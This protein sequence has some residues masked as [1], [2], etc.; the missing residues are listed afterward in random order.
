MRHKA[1]L[2]NDGTIALP[3]DIRRILGVEEGGTIVFEADEH[4]VHLFTEQKKSFESMRGIW[5]HLGPTTIEQIIEEQREMRGWDEYDR[6][7]ADEADEADK[8][9]HRD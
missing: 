2:A 7:L 3:P 6:K 8:N 4:G 9:D 5:S 1:T